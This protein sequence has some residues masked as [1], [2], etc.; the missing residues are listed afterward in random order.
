MIY[1]QGY[2]LVPMQKLNLSVQYPTID[3]V[4]GSPMVT[5]P[6]SCVLNYTTLGDTFLAGT[7][8]RGIRTILII[9]QNT[10]LGFQHS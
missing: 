3:D 1:E 9:C 6:P 5:L 7:T 10:L 2:Y 4:G 8:R